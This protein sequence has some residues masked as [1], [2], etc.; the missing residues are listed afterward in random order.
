MR[1]SPT[2]AREVDCALTPFAFQL[3]S[4]HAS[5]HAARTQ[6]KLPGPRSVYWLLWKWRFVVLAS[7]AGSLSL[8]RDTVAATYANPRA[9]VT[10]DVYELRRDG[11][12][13]PSGGA[14]YD[15]DVLPKTDANTGTSG[16]NRYFQRQNVARGWPTDVGYWYTAAD[17][18]EGEPDPASEQWVDY[19]PP[20]EILGPGRYAIDA[21]YRWSATRASYPAVYRVHHGLGT[22]EVLRDQR[23]GSAAATIVYFSLGEFEMRPGSFVRVEDTGSESITFAHMRFRLV[24]PAPRLRITF[25]DG[26]CFLRWPVISTGYRL[27]CSDTPF[28]TTSWLPVLDPSWIEGDQFVVH[29][30]MDGPPKFFRLVNP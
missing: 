30:F 11:W 28:V 24:T 14:A 25:A 2:D 27:E 15:G 22:N 16:D 3:E 26:G 17:Q 12:S 13:T 4:G 8:V 20:F 18:H 19:V 10:G 21:S 5:N 6:M 23:I 1:I 9:L 29:M 7:V